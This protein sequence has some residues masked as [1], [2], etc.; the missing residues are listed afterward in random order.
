MK[1]NL[2]LKICILAIGNGDGSDLFFTVG[3]YDG[4]LGMFQLKQDNQ[5]ETNSCK[6]KKVVLII[7]TMFMFVFFSVW[8]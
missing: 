2:F 5:L 7:T 8:T 3:N 6:V 1:T 4:S